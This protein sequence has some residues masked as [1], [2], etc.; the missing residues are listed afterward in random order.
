MRMNGQRSWGGGQGAGANATVEQFLIRGLATACQ[1]YVVGLPRS[2][3]RR[4]A[5]PLPILTEDSP[6]GANAL[7]TASGTAWIVFR[8]DLPRFRGDVRA[9]D[10]GIWS[11]II[12]S[13][14]ERT[15]GA[16]FTLK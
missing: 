13:S 14:N 1:A 3:P 6:T 15:Q 7:A 12:L 2:D 5:S 9:W 4:S 10:Q 8:L 11:D 16:G